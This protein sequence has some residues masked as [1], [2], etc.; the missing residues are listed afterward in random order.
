MVFHTAHKRVN[1]P[2]LKLSNVV[3]AR[4]SQYHFLGV[5]LDSR[6]K[7]D[8]HIAH[9]SLKISTVSSVLL[10]TK[11]YYPQEVLLTLY[12]TVIFSYLHCCIFVWGSK[13]YTEHKFRKV[14]RTITNQDYI[15]HTEP[16]CKS[17]N[18]LKGTDMF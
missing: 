4:V 9:I 10:M 14:V 2:V 11:H 12:N 3:I 6:L 16:L 8:K 7:W 17:L 18:I 1:S 15:A 5:I 13:I